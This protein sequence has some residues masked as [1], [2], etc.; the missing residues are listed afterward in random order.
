MFDPTF[1]VIIKIAPLGASLI[2]GTRASPW[3]VQMKLVQRGDGYTM[4]AAN[5]L[6]PLPGTFV[7]KQISSSFMKR[8][9]G[10]YYVKYA[11]PAIQPEC[12]EAVLPSKA[13]IRSR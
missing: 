12:Q 13:T 4:V 2:L 9:Y 1:R 3:P 10:T 5:T 8:L 7:N 6:L 11:L